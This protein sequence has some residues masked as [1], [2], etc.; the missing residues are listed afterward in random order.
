M[1]ITVVSWDVDGTLYDMGPMV[2]HVVW[3][4]LGGLC[5]RPL[6][7]WRE[8]GRLRRFRRAMNLVRARGGALLPGDVPAD[9]GE[10]IALEERWYGRAI[11]RVGLRAGVTDLIA[12]LRARGLRQIVVSDYRAEY[13]LRLLGLEGAFDRVYAGEDLGFLKPAPQLLA[14]V[15]RDLGVAPAHILHLG[16]R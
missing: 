15:A 11:A 6:R 7:T 16:D 14:A 2:R 12:D 9:R 4:G 1:P 13:K 3:L 5:A 8:L 10:L